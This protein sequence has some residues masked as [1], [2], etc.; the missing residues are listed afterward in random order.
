MNSNSSRS[1]VSK[2]IIQ[3]YLK[4][5]SYTSNID[6]FTLVELLVSI[7]IIGLLSAIALPGFLNQASKVRGSE[8]KSFLGTINRSQQSYRIA[9]GSFAAQLSDLDVRVNGKFYSY[10]VGLVDSQNA[11]ATTSSIT[12][13]DLKLYSAAV[14]QNGDFFGQIICESL[15]ANTPAGTATPPTTPEN[16]GS[17][18]TGSI[19]VD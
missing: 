12:S 1:T 14:T 15:A 17:C 3:Q 11:W 19:V 10:Q 9:N 13:N 7:V 5:F 2:L 6:G 18:A 16:S 4:H 8:A